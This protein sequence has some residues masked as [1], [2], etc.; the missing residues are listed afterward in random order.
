[1]EADLVSLAVSV[2]GVR[3]QSSDLSHCQK[4]NFPK[5]SFLKGVKLPPSVL[6]L[7]LQLKLIE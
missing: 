6:T 5:C 3:Y 1:M 4:A 2:F 7:S